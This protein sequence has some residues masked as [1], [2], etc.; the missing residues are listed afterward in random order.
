MRAAE[1][2][3]EAEK[4]KP[5]AKAKRRRAKKGTGTLRAAERGERLT[6][7][8]PDEVALRL[9]VFSATERRSMSDVV[10]A[11]LDRYLPKR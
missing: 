4:P 2:V 3:Q 8:I 7:L 11:A 6:L 5:A 1:P 10:T 9:R